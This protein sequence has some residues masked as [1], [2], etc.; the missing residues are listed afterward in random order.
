MSSFENKNKNKNIIQDLKL[1]LNK[2]GI[3]VRI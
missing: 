2:N 1:Y 3:L